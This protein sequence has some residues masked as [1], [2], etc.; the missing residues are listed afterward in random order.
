[1]SESHLD[2]IFPVTSRP[3]ESHGVFVP[4][5]M[6]VGVLFSVA[7]LLRDAFRWVGGN[8]LERRTALNASAAVAWLVDD[9]NPD[10]DDMGMLPRASYL[11]SAGLFISG[12]LYVAIGSIANFLRD[13][14]Y[15]AD[16][17][18]LLGLSLALSVVLIFLGV[19]A[20]SAFWRW[21]C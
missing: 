9:G 2:R 4:A 5:V 12:S 21:P 20:L 13:G 18:W 10:P 19:V 16:I 3:T 14:G 1:M 6:S 8:A 17:G 11:V 7:T 15:V